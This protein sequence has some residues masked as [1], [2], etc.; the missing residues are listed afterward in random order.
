MARVKLP[1]EII[2]HYMRF[3][4]HGNE[5]SKRPSNFCKFCGKQLHKETNC[6][7]RRALARIAKKKGVEKQFYDIADTVEA[8]PKYELFTDWEIDNLIYVRAF[9]DCKTSLKKKWRY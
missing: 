3:S 2:L 4:G 6:P 7:Y 1:A 5:G 9:K 8:K